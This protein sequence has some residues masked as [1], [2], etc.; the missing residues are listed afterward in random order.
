MESEMIHAEQLTDRVL[1]P[2]KVAVIDSGIDFTEELNVTGRKMLWT[3]D[4]WYHSMK[5]LRD[6]EP[7]LLGSLLQ[8]RLEME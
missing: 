1:K 2:I 4:T 7:V 8:E 6:T 5:I 3:K